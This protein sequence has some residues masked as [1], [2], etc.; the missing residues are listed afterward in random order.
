V[1]FQYKDSS[2]VHE[3]SPLTLV[4]YRSALYLVAR[5][6]PDSRT[7]LF[8]IDRVSKLEL[9]RKRFDYPADFS[10]EGL[11][12]GAFGIF[13]G[14]EE[15][16]VELVFSDKPWLHRYL[17]ERCWHPTQSFEK[18]DDGTLRM[19]FAVSSMVEVEP[20]IRSFGEDVQRA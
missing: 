14:T 12:E 20:W 11:F 15:H 13:Q 18:L 10:P 19:R 16:A 9:T 4:M 8:A 17:T 1:R 2:K 6:R 5:Y 3:V 7:Y